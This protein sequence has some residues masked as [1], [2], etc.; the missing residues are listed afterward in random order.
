MFKKI[1]VKEIFEMLETELNNE[2][3]ININTNIDLENGVV[4]GDEELTKGE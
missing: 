1:T 3:Q 2:N 4:D